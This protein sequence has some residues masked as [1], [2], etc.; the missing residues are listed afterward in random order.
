MLTN[1]AMLKKVASHGDVRTLQPMEAALRA[2]TKDGT[3]SK[4]HS[5]VELKSILAWR[6]TSFYAEIYGLLPQMAEERRRF[7]T[8]S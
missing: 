8:S 2:R 7:A 3:L 1:L 6:M 4:G 5:L